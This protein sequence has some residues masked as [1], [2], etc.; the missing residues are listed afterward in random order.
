MIWKNIHVSKS[1]DQNKPAPQADRRSNDMEKSSCLLGTACPLNFTRHYLR[2]QS[3]MR[4]TPF[5][6]VTTRYQ[7]EQCPV[8]VLLDLPCGK[9]CV[10]ANI[11]VFPHRGRRNQID[12]MASSRR[13]IKSRPLCSR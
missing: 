5:P 2:V 1:A 8:K 6:K 7:L 12:H 10:S 11:G 13:T 3:R 9:F 4:E